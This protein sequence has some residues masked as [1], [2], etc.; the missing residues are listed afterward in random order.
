MTSVR[1]LLFIAQHYVGCFNYYDLNLKVLSNQLSDEEFSNCVGFQNTLNSSTL[2]ERG[3]WKDEK[4]T[5]SSCL[6]FCLSNGQYQYAALYNNSCLCFN[7]YSYSDRN[8]SK[9]T[10]YLE[11]YNITEMGPGICTLP[12]PGFNRQRCGGPAFG[13]IFYTN[14]YQ[15]K[16]NELTRLFSIEY[17]CTQWR[18]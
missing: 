6:Q 13:M 12:C 1:Y 17:T 5:I 2:I 9:F 10:N 11:G 16:I 18:S 8:I 7:K 3:C 4:M 15:G 14:I